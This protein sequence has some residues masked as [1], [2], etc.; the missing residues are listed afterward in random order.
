MSFAQVWARASGLEGWLTEA[1]GRALWDAASAVAPGS[2]LVEIGSFRG[3]SAIVLA[4]AMPSGCELVCVDPYLG[5]DRGPQELDADAGRGEADLAAFSANV[6]AAGVSERLRPVRA[7]S[8]EALDAVPG[9]VALLWVD[10]AHRFG[11]AR[12]DL[13]RWGAKVVP[14]GT[15]LVHDGFSSVGVTLALLAAP[16]VDGGWRWD[17]RAG[18]LV[19]YRRVPARRRRE[20]ARHAVHLPWFGWNLGLKALTVAGVRRGP[21]PH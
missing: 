4:S 3:R 14:G 12:D 8:A 15:M 10:G 16:A 18:S 5:S 20:L 6:L 17:G 21:W 9:P 11:P 19:R 1:Q 13:R 2:T 7:R